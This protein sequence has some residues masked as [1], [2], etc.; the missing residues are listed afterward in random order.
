MKGR[1]HLCLGLVAFVCAGASFFATG[2][3]AAAAATVP[4][5][6]SITSITQI[7]LDVDPGI[8]QGPVGDFYAG[9]TIDGGPKQDNFADRLDFGFEFGTGFIFPFFIP[10]NP[11]WTFTQDVDSAAGSANVAIELWDNDD[12]SH[13]F[14]NDTGIFGN[15]DDQ[16]DIAP[17]GSETLNLTV[18]LAD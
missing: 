11:P 14:C 18:N 17:T 2:P 9:V 13:P 4:V 16:V 10:L 1:H 12:C 15:D 7:G 8:F 5:T 3:H 6:V